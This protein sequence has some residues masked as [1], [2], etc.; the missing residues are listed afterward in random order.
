MARGADG[1]LL[2]EKQL[3]ELNRQRFIKA[4]DAGNLYNT[5]PITDEGGTSF[6]E[7]RWA[8]YFKANP[9]EAPSDWTGDS[10]SYVEKPK[11][12]QE[13]LAQ[14]DNMEVYDEEDNLVYAD[15]QEVVPSRGS[16]NS[17]LT[18]DQAKAK[19]K[20]DISMRPVSIENFE[21]EDETVVTSDEQVPA[22]EV[23]AGIADRRAGA[24]ARA[25]DRASRLEKGL[26]EIEARDP[27]VE[28]DIEQEDSVENWTAHFNSMSEDNF[29][30]ITAEDVASL[31]ENAQTAFNEKK[32]MTQ[33]LDEEL[34]GM[35]SKKPVGEDSKADM[36]KS[37]MINAGLDEAQ[38]AS[39]L[40]K[41][42][43]ICN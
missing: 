32:G 22:E 20:S 18:A 6:G 29:N 35:L 31:T 37:A 13:F 19:A 8:A 14:M 42:K 7:D 38:S 43:G 4:V 12:D 21:E 11:T 3:K 23:R 27:N 15:G 36:M 5:G 41:L 33:G 25:L 16:D 17:F 10:K 2:T 26:A 1:S 39:L 28:A 34:G 30:S 40:G 9:E 24:D